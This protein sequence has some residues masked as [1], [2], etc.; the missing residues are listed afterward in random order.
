MS[1]PTQKVLTKWLIRFRLSPVPRCSGK[2]RVISKAL[3]H[4]LIEPPEWRTMRK[5]RLGRKCTLGVLASLGANTAQWLPCG[6]PKS[7]ER[8]IPALCSGFLRP[9]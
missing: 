1:L 3:I 9:R 2:P 6:T 8:S 7:R 4:R 5:R